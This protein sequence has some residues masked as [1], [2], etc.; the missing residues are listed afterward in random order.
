MSLAPISNGSFFKNNLLALFPPALS[1][2]N[3]ILLS[4]NFPFFK[5]IFFLF[6]YLENQTNTKLKDWKDEIKKNIPN[7]GNRMG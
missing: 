6:F 5:M 7:I 2:Q 3:V 4:T 1:L